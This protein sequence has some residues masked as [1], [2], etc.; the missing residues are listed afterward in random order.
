MADMG[1]HLGRIASM[2]AV[3]AGYVR[4]PFPLAGKGALA[5]VRP[6]DLAAQV[7]RALIERTGVDAGAAACRQRVHL[8]VVAR[9]AAVQVEEFLNLAQGEPQAFSPQDQPHPHDV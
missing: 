9:V 7:V 6:E 1:G 4:S 8:F 3:L 5:R 2:K